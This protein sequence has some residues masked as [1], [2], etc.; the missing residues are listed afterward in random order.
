MVSPL[1][2]TIFGQYFFVLYVSLI[3]HAEN[4]EASLREH[5][6]EINQSMKII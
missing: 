1:T 4:M 5:Q 3:S 6:T 2:N